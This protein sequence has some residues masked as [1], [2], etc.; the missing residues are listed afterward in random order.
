[1]SEPFLLSGE[2]H[3]FR[4]PRPEWADRLRS[5]RDA[6]L[7][8]VS[9]YVP[10]NWHQPSAGPFDFTGRSCPE[11]DLV[12]ALESIA[13]AGL[14][15]IYRP[16]PFITAEWRNGGIPDWLLD[17]EPDIRARSADGS[18]TAGGGYPAITYAHPAYR[19]A[20]QEW[21][22]AA[23]G[24]AGGFFAREG[25][26][27]DNVQ[28][29]DEPS[30]WQR[31]GNAFA[32]DYHP[33]LVGPDPHGSLWARFVIERHGS[34][35]A[36]AAAH[37][38]DWRRPEDVDPPRAL[39][40]DPAELPRYLDWLDFKL[41]QI[42]DY[43][44]FCY[45]VVRGCGVTERL[46]ML[47]PYLTSLQATKFSRS[48][49]RRG[50]DLQTT[51]ECYLSLL[52]PSTCTEQ[53][54]AAVIAT[55]ETYRLWHDE[56]YGPPVT[57]EMQSANASYLAPGA[58]EMLYALTVA[59]G[60]R[61]ISY[62]MMVG[63]TNPAGYENETGATYDIAAPIAADG[64]RRPHFAT[65]E[66]L[67]RVVR[68]SEA[69][70]LAARPLY[71]VA[72][73]AVVDYDS[74]SM[75]G[76]ALAVDVWGPGTIVSHGD[77]GLSESNGV[78]TLFATSSV[79][80][81]MVDLAGQGD[82]ELDASPQCWVASASY[83]P[84]AIQRRLARYVA[85]GG[86][87]VLLPA[88]PTRDERF[89]D[90]RTLSDLVFGRTRPPSFAGFTGAG[91]SSVVRIADGDL[92]VVPG[93]ISAIELPEGA[94]PLAWDRDGRAVAFTRIV[95]QGRVT[96]LGFRL[97]YDPDG[98]GGAGR[99]CRQIV[100]TGGRRRVASTESGQFAAFQLAGPAGGL[101]CLV[102]PVEVPGR[103]ACWYTP[104]EGPL[105]AEPR[106]LPAVM[107]AVSF[108][109]RG[110]RLLPVDRPL[111]SVGQIVQATAEL[112]SSREGAGSV[113][114]EL[115]T[116]GGEAVEVVVRGED[117]GPCPE[118]SAVDGTVLAVVAGPRPGEQTVILRPDGKTLACTVRRPIRP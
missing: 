36:A 5:V 13:A 80:W 7:G 2:F 114:L 51:D 86:H 8:A 35:A 103:T 90:D 105:G 64:S 9:I 68:A 116:P 110:A 17:A 55:H 18:V 87:L 100:E 108:F 98:G 99:L 106:R 60:V 25:G 84:A 115:D 112:V 23:I 3:Y 70:I 39:M 104:A 74:A 107:A 37:G 29:D 28:L 93:Q 26:P 111:P 27:I 102:N 47:Y 85:G 65:I 33:M 113:E 89:E 38:G 77:M 49:R 45:E 46:S 52:G 76:A 31:I 83:M 118:V 58:M 50:L 10:W 94:R 78:T 57:M 4:V 41:T 96:V 61:G 88:V 1:M 73:G 97:E 66:K 24:A 75:G 42:D 30:Y 56:A 69:A 71:D 40:S 91:E 43:V 81:K 109:G 20:A 92:I 34:L 117:G 53:K 11:R 6:G 19:R 44:A 67:S 12:R 59:R 72:V 62:Y 14:R 32:V 21:L 95:G 15:C 79:S 16:G 101:V 82:G 63:G 48:A 22:E 54:M